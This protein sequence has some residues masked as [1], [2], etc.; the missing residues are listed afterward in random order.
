MN[1]SKECLGRKNEC[2]YEDTMIKKAQ[3]DMSKNKFFI[4]TCNLNVYNMASGFTTRSQCLFLRLNFLR[5]IKSTEINISCVVIS[6]FI[7]YNTFV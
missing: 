6:S 2:L 4:E 3:S 1:L 7:T 5:W